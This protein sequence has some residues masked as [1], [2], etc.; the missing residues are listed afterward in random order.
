MTP[1][2]LDYPSMLQDAVRGV[3]RAA[4]AE[5]AELGMPGEHHF[6]V[7]FRTD[8]PE[9]EL[10]ASLRQTYP[11]EMTIVLQ[12]QFWGLTVDER[13]FSVT[14]AF[15]R[16]RRTITVPFAAVTGF[17]D[18]AASFE[19]RLG[20]APRSEDAEPPGDDATPATTDASEAPDDG[21]ADGGT[22]VDLDA[23]RKR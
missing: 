12:H 17:V 22:V 4:L 11:E 2:R 6:Y 20:P 16:A 8:H 21:A 7:H 1:K 9:V 18:P 3:V 13:A 14:L 19:L 23:F 10:P 5:V 15:D